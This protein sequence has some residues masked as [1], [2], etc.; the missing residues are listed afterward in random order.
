[1]LR[2]TTIA[3][4]LLLQAVPVLAQSYELP[5]PKTVGGESSMLWP[6]LYGLAFL[7][8]CMAVA[9]KPAKRANLQ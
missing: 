6:W 4:G 1:M 9:F 2:L 7:I 5:Q 8:G 3:A